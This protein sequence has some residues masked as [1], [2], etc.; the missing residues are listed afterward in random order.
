MAV[1]GLGLEKPVVGT[2]VPSI[3]S[4]AQMS[5]E[6]SPFALEGPSFPAV[7]L[8]PQSRQAMSLDRQCM[9][10]SCNY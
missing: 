7:T 9:A 10:E 6:N 4:F 1:S 8:F 2:S 3:S 5:S